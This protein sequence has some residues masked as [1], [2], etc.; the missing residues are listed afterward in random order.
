MARDDDDDEPLV[1][2]LLRLL[3]VVVK[4]VLIVVALPLLVVLKLLSKTHLL[5]SDYKERLLTKWMGH[6]L[7]YVWIGWLPRLLAALSVLAV[8]FGEAYLIGSVVGSTLGL[9]SGASI[10]LMFPALLLIGAGAWAG[11]STL[12]VG[13]TSDTQEPLSASLV[14][15][16]T[17]LSLAYSLGDFALMFLLFLGVITIVRMPKVLPWSD[18]GEHVPHAQLTSFVVLQPFLAVVDL[19]G[20]VL[21]AAIWLTRLRYPALRHAREQASGASGE[22]SEVQLQQRLAVLQQFLGLLMD[23]PALLCGCLVYCTFYRV[24]KMRHDLAQVDIEN[25]PEDRR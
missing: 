1:L 22:Y 23:L 25:R 17:V 12:K 3:L 20:F 13:D 15:R 9:S 16:N 14:A 8:S 19:I 2:Q 11:A 4:W 21:F 18:P 5:S 6:R 7:L 10:G 24:G